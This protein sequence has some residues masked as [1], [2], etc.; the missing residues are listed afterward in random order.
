MNRGQLEPFSYE[1]AVVYVKVDEK[2]QRVTE[3]LDP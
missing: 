1:A 3:L 2:Y